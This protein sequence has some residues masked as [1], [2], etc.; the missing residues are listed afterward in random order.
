[1]KQIGLGI[2]MYVKDYDERFPMWSWTNSGEVPPG[3]WAG[4]YADTTNAFT[5]HNAVYPYTQ[6]RQIYVC[7]SSRLTASGGLMEGQTGLNLALIRTRVD[8]STTNNL[9]SV[10][11][12]AGT[13]MVMDYGTYYAHPSEALTPGGQNAFLP[14]GGPHTTGNLPAGTPSYKIDDF[15]GG[16]HFGGVNMGFADGHVKWLKSEVVVAEAAKFNRLTPQVSAWDPRT[17]NQ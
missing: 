15:E 16:R 14:G 11:S 17:N 5:W 10:V 12:A 8:I 7:P 13:Y 3:G 6:T 4:N 9:A 1:L 2:M